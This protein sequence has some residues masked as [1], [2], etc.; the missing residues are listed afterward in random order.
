MNLS[1]MRYQLMAVITLL[2]VNTYAQEVLPLYAGKIPNSK[3]SPDTESEA[4]NADSILIVSN[5]SRPS[6]TVFLPDPAKATGEA[7]IVIPGGGYHILAAGHEGVDVA[8]RFNEFGIATFVLKY[9]IPDTTWMIRKETGPIQDAQR[10]IQLVRENAKKWNINPR[11]V[12][13][14]GFSAGG[15]LAATAATHFK[16]AYVPKKK[17]ISFR[18]DF[19]I[20]IYPVISFVDT[21]SHIGSKDNLLG[22]NAGNEMQREYSAELQVT[23]ETPPTFLVHAKDDPVSVRNTI[24]FADSL[25]AKG[26]FSEVLLYDTGGHGFGLVNK[27]SE[28][29]WP[30]RVVKWLRELD[31]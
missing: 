18:P 22:A 27:S 31:K 13:V 1:F 7:I 23:P 16:K 6:L 24:L 17:N 10:A 12:G 21:T 14:L 20:L 28:I 25:N 11:K 15:H 29:Q 2:A 3:P 19:A 26:V 5:V 30:E 9:R 4:T 8:R